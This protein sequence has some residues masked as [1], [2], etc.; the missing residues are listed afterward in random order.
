MT[1]CNH[2]LRFIDKG[3]D[4]EV[5]VGAAFAASAFAIVRV[6]IFDGEDGFTALIPHEE[7]RPLL[8]HGSDHLAMIIISIILMINSMAIITWPGGD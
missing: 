4:V 8:L 7:A 6:R 2:H 1:M 3:H 5:N